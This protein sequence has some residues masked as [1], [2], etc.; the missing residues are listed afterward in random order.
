MTITGAFIKPY[1]IL[2][3]LCVELSAYSRNRSL[4]YTQGM[5]LGFLIGVVF[6]AGIFIYHVP[7]YLVIAEYAAKTYAGQNTMIGID[8]L[9]P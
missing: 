9:Y 1:F 2:T 4:N 5:R 7:E 6:W 3:L 8:P